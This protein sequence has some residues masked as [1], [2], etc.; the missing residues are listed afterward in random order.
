MKLWRI[1]CDGEPT[2]WCVYALD[3]RAAT[4]KAVKLLPMIGDPDA[5]VWVEAAERLARDKDPMEQPV[6]CES[7][8]LEWED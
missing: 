8:E 4:I 5:Y 7:I 3:E 6:K 1:I 2:D